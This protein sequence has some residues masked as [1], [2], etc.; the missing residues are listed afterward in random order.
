MGFEW[1]PKL[2]LFPSM[3]LIKHYT[4]K[5]GTESSEEGHDILP[6]YV[7][8]EWGVVFIL[9]GSGKSSAHK[10]ALFPVYHLWVE[11]ESHTHGKNGTYYLLLSCSIC[12]CGYWICLNGSLDYFPFWGK[13]LEFIFNMEWIHLIYC[14]WFISWFTANIYNYVNFLWRGGKPFRFI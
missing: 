6:K 3:L 10:W 1:T 11:N 8:N 5:N 13:L 9:V 12:F 4:C 14:P 7:K 2:T